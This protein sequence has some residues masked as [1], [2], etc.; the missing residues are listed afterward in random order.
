LLTTA[1]SGCAPAAYPLGHGW[2]LSFF[3][4]SATH[5]SFPCNGPAGGRDQGEGER[6]EA[7]RAKEAQAW[8]ERGDEAVAV[9]R[10]GC[11]WKEDRA[12]GKR[13]DAAMAVARD[14]D[15]GKG[16]RPFSE[17]WDEAV[18]AAMASTRVGSGERGGEL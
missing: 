7:N 17:R 14:G 13:G 15:R 12:W 4:K 9:A 16:G 11:R 2:A 18:A 8:G 5:P 1:A 6:E 10:E 3:S